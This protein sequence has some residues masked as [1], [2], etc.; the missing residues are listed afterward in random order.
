MGGN[1]NPTPTVTLQSTLAELLNIATRERK[2]HQIVRM[3]MGQGREI[4]IVA[5]VE[6]S[7]G[8][9]STIQNYADARD[10]YANR[11]AN[12]VAADIAEN[13]LPEPGTPFNIV[14][15]SDGSTLLP[16][17]EGATSD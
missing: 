17:E 6:D 12:A 9:L 14:K 5:I 3:D 13:G 10:Q 1:V 2:S 4:A 8:Y 16:P 7:D 11:V 15:S